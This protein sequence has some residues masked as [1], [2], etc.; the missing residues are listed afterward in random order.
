VWGGGG[1]GGGGGGCGGGGL[2]STAPSHLPLCVPYPSATGGRGGGNPHG[3]R[4]HAQPA[5][6]VAAASTAH[7][8]RA[9]GAGGGCVG[10]R[11]RVATRPLGPTPWVRPW[12]SP[13]P[14]MASAGGLSGTAGGAL[15]R[16]RRRPA[17]AAWSV[18]GV[19]GGRP[20]RRRRLGRRRPRPGAAAAVAAA[21]ATAAAAAL[22]EA[23]TC[24]D[25]REAA[26]GDRAAAAAGGGSTAAGA[27]ALAAAA[28][29][30]AGRCAW[31]KAPV[32]S[33]QTRIVPCSATLGCRLPSGAI[34][35]RLAPRGTT[36][37]AVRPV[38]PRT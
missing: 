36:R 10:R 11:R 14:V 3:R 34:N 18:L 32:L 22:A 8:R 24:A 6:G 27:S 9:G 1:G 23:A 17:V 38:S 26:N 31:V 28:A 25:A 21:A 37:V 29:A 16:G 12:A 2:T 7:R 35:T 30:R 13:A 20:L 5:V 33:P 4:P 19:W 15:C